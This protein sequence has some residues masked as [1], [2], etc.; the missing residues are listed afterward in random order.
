[1]ERYR[2][3]VGHISILFSLKK[4]GRAKINVRYMP[5]CVFREK[6]TKRYPN[7]VGYVSI[8]AVVSEKKI[9]IDR[10]EFLVGVVIVSVLVVLRL[11]W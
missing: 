4:V 11:L 3:P 10:F 9:G 6:K 5:V 2:H 8:F 7:P 1:M